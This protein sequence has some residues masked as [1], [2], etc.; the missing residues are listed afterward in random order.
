MK[1]SFKYSTIPLL[2]TSFLANL[3]TPDRVFAVCPV[4]TLAVG[5]GLF[6]AQRYGVDNTISG[7]WIGAFL[8]S[9]AMWALNWMKKKNYQFPGEKALIPVAFYLFVL[10]PL[11]FKKIIGKPLDK[12]WGLDKLVLGIVLGS[13]VFYLSEYL[14]EKIKKARGDKPYFPFQKVIMPLS[15]LAILSIIFYHLTKIHTH[16]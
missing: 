6:F 15:F 14:Y 3:L 7:I 5:S 10:V 16:G 1:S 8:T 11:Y 9:G 4:C 2:L 13:I 12:I